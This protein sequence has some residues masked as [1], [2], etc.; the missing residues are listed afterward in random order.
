M[1]KMYP[2]VQRS[3]AT[4]TWRSSV[5]S[6]TARSPST[7]PPELGTHLCTPSTSAPPPSEQ[8]ES[9]ATDIGGGGGDG[10][11]GGGLGFGGGVGGSGGGGGGFHGSWQLMIGVCSAGGFSWND[12]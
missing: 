12:T 8:R 10:C 4:W 5:P 7:Q 9:D 1:S 11:S 2:A 6:S 3:I